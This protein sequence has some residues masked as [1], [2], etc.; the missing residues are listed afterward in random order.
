MRNR[1]LAILAALLLAS[2]AAAQPRW[3]REDHLEPEASTIGGTAVLEGYD[4]TVREILHDAYDMRVEVRMV[5][6]PSFSPEY[7]VGLRSSKTYGWGA[8]YRLFALSP[9]AQIWTYNSIAMLK[10]GMEKVGTWRNDNRANQQDLQKREIARLEASVPANPRDLKVDGCDI[11][12]SEV[13][14]DR[15]VEVWR[16]MVLATHYSAKY[17]TILDGEFYHFAMVSPKAGLISGQTH[18]PYRDS[19]TGTLVALADTMRAV[20]EK[21]ATMTE[22]DDLTTELEQRL[23]KGGGK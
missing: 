9:K 21:K 6:L 2:P 13:L 4:R 15:I 19:A 7:A 1:L 16:K 23:Q 5:A 20:C 10:S 14:G 11:P 22:L 3:Q 18:S 12:L 8:P 17:D